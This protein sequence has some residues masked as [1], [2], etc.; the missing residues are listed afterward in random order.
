MQKKKLTQKV[1]LLTDGFYFKIGIAKNVIG[2]INKLQ[3]GNP[4]R[5]KEVFSYPLE[6]AFEIEKRLHKKFQNKQMVGEWFDL[7][8]SDV[9]AIKK[10][11]KS[12]V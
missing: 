1:Y 11:L 8:K 9:R 7:D 10:Y 12:L 5:I 3:I 6:N 4:H 2:R